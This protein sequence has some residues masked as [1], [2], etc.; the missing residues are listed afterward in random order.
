[1]WKKPGRPVKQ[2][3]DDYFREFLKDYEKLTNAQ[4]ADKYQIS[5]S[6]VQRTLKKAMAWADERGIN[7]G[8]NITDNER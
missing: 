5:V 3:N 8:D 2:Y 7:Y 6:T 1:M 4:M